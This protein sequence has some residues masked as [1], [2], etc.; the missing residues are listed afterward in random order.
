[1]IEAAAGSN[2]LIVTG[3]GHLSG[4]AAPGHFDNPI[5]APGARPR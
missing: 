1:M 3:A 5:A 4:A 2:G